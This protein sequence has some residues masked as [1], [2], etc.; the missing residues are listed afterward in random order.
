MSIRIIDFRPPRIALF[1]VVIAALLHWATPLNYINVYSSH[2][3]G[4]I[5]GL[6]GFT[7]MIWGWWLFKKHGVAICPTS[8]TARLVTHAIYRFTR[9]PMYLGLIL[10]L[11]GLAIYVGT[12]PFYLAAVA[13]FVV[14]NWVFCPYEEA[15]LVNVFGQE[16]LNYKSR[17]RRWL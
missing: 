8:A 16:Y 3:F 5:L 17:V 9:N 12:S 11:V 13:F 1:L 14:I 7:M 6:V 2:M 10:M 15:K 4:A